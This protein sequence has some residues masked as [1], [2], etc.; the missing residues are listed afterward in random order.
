MMR[1][2][3]LSL[4]LPETA[5]LGSFQAPIARGAAIYYPPPEAGEPFGVSPHTDY[6][7]LT[8][9]Y[10]DQVGGLEVL[11]RDGD[12][13]TAHPIEDTFVVNVGDLLAR[14]SNDGLRSTPH[15]VINRA[16]RERFS[17]AVA[18]D[19]ESAAGAKTRRAPIRAGVMTKAFLGYQYH[20]RPG[21]ALRPV[22]PL[23]AR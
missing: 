5:F 11:G 3:A 8:L 7:C 6:G 23:L 15:R 16:G 9:L 14:W 18:W 2:F 13:V 21:P 22:E 20:L 4:D 10:Q 12:W 1:A 19:P 17:L